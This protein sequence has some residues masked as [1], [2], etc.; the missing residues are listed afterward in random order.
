MPIITFWNSAK[1]QT[2]QTISA[3]SLATNMAI[4]QNIKILLIS[5]SLNDNT[6]KDCLWT[7]KPSMLSSIFGANVNL[8]NQNGIEGLDRIVRSNKISPDLV[9]DYTKVVLKGRLEV[10]LGPTGTEEQYEELCKQYLEIVLAANQYYNIVIV[11][12][13]REMNKAIQKEIL[14]RSDIIIPIVS[15]RKETI[16]QNINYFAKV[17]DVS[18]NKAIFTIGK[19][20]EKSKY[21]IKNIAR[22][23]AKE[24]NTANIS[25]VISQNTLLFDASQDGGIVD[26]LLDFSR[27]KGKDENTELINQLTELGND[28]K[29]KI[30]QLGK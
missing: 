5:T 1:E 30:N 12:L 25:N 14:K 13:A 21:N 22:T 16:K 24:K 17:P 15:Q 29:L 28:I 19:Y 11:D 26:L 27:L 10:L 9:K 3:V 4:Q 18:I 20:N 6:M 7:E 8:V 23:M 2:G